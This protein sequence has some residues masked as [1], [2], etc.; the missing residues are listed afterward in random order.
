MSWT[1]TFQKRTTLPGT[2]HPVDLY[3]IKGPGPKDLVA[4]A[5]DEKNRSMV[6]KILRALAMTEAA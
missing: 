2:A 1:A 5:V 3:T 4:I 6:D